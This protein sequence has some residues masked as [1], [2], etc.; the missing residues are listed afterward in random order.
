MSTATTILASIDT[1]IALLV[2]DPNE[3][4]SYK[5]GNKQVSKSDKMEWLLKAREKY[6]KIVE[7]EPYEDIKHVAL[8]F[9]EFG[10]DESELIGDEL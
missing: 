10:A 1:Q 4:V 7:V 2:D 8:D 9:D 3:I 6:Q 5:I